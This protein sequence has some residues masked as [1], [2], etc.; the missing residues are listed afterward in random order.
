M[1]IRRERLLQAPFKQ[2]LVLPLSPFLNRVL[3][4]NL[5]P[6]RE[7]VVLKLVVARAC[8]WVVIRGHESMEYHVLVSVERGLRKLRK[9]IINLLQN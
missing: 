5:T 3:H 7:I 9:P 4:S 2:C 6:A 8:A 1:R